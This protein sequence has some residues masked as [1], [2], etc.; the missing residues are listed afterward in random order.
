MHALAAFIPAPRLLTGTRSP[1]AAVL[2]ISAPKFKSSVNTKRNH[3]RQK[4]GPA[5]PDLPVLYPEK[6]GRETLIDLQECFD[7]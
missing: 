6:S 5:T 7:R 2:R 3:V 4:A 1:S